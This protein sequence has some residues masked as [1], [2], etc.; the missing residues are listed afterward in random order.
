MSLLKEEIVEKIKQENAELKEKIDNTEPRYLEGKKQ[1]LLASNQESLQSLMDNQ[2][3]EL[4]R[5]LIELK[6]EHDQLNLESHRI[7]SMIDEYDKRIAMLQSA[8]EAAKVA[9]E[10]Q[11]ENFDFMDKGIKSKKDRKSEEEFTKKSLIKQKEKLNRDIFV[12]QKSIIDEESKSKDLDKKFERAAINENIIKEQ[13]NKVYSKTQN[14]KQKNNF[15]KNENDL[16]IQQYKKIIELKSA[17]LKFSD[18]R[19]EIQDQIAQQAK[20]DSQDKQEVEKRKTLKLLMLYNQYL[21]TLMDEELKENDKLEQIYE[22]IRDITGTNNLDQIVDFIVL[23][24]K[25]YNYACNQVNDCEEW[26]KDLK[27]EIK[28]LKK[29]LVQ[30][31]N[32]LLVDEKDEKEI[33]VDV[34]TNIEEEKDLIEKEKQKNQN[35][36]EIGKKYNEVD[37]AYQNVLSNISAMI[38]NEKKNPLNVKIEET[39]KEESKQENEGEGKGE[40]KKEEETQFELTN[41][42]HKRFN[43]VVYERKERNELDKFKLTEEEELIVKNAELTDKEKKDIEKNELNVLEKIITRSDYPN[44]YTEEEMEIMDEIENYQLT[45]EQQEAARDIKL[46]EEEEKVA[47][48]RLNDEKEVTEEKKKEKIDNFKLLK[49]KYEKYKEQ[50]KKDNTRYKLLKM[51]K[52][53]V[54]MINDYELLL[55]KVERKFDTLYLIYNKQEFM[56]EMKQKQIAEQN[57]I[58]RSQQRK[59]TRKGTKR[60]TNRLP[61]KRYQKTESYKIIAEDKNEEE[62]DKSN[63]EV[64]T[65]ILTR[66]LNEQ[67][68]EKENFVSGKVKIE[69]KK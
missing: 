19:K 25:R 36:L 1:F 66:F 60:M 42:E 16:K 37:E 56:N 17:F 51:K 12:I 65:N 21:R 49:A 54:D 38:E 23:R 4:T 32:N 9:E 7:Q 62:E 64:D 33:E 5:V 50:E 27:K 59:N 3:A 13:K 24:N 68:K 10:K 22:Q 48:Q 31:K 26:N 11:K 2:N 28:E 29:E 58:V 8:D 61:N 41:D 30:L 67:R 46:K 14:Q 15:N 43:L 34:S 39:K 57:E 40:Q 53:K 44:M 69:E 20:N 35:L 45:E 63:Y 18:E 47:I 6:S 55:K 52:N